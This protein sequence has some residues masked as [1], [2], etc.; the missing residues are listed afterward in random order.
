M[1]QSLLL[2]RISKS[3]SNLL[4]RQKE[5]DS[6]IKNILKE[7]AQVFMLTISPKHAN[8]DLSN[9][10]SNQRNS[11]AAHLTLNQFNFNQLI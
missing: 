11:K 6:N 2:E 7:T 5:I 4:S 8:S 10:L 3:S 9:K 1:A